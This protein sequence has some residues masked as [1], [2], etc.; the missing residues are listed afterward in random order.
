MV[1]TANHRTY[2]K[3]LLSLGRWTDSRGN[4]VDLREGDLAAIIQGSP[5]DIPLKLGHSSDAFNNLV[6]QEM[7]I[8]LTALSGDEFGNGQLRLGIAGNFRV[9]GDRLLADLT[10]PAELGRLIDLG[11]L[12]NV[13]A[14]MRPGHPFVL[15]ALALLGAEDPAVG[16]LRQFAGDRSDMIYLTSKQPNKQP[17]KQQEARHMVMTMEELVTA[18]RDLA[19]AAVAPEENPEEPPMEPEETPMAPPPPALTAARPA[20][21]DLTATRQLSDRVSRLEQENRSLRLTARQVHYSQIGAAYPHIEDSA[22]FGVDMAQ[23]ELT[24]PAAVSMMMTEH[25]R[26]ADAH[27]NSLL[28]T[29]MSVKPVVNP[30]ASTHPFT[31]KME[32][33][34]SREGLNLSNR[35][36]YAR[37]FTKASEEYRD[38][39]LSYSSTGN[40]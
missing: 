21:A 6:A 26:I 31:V 10:V 9:E 1:T 40:R 36:E 2:T 25:E 27:N 18:L 12:V 20:A 33:L 24:A 3:E 30:A 4:L 11:M 8:P 37:A 15:T 35:S 28:F 16:N 5:R 14:E 23:L 34:A 38:L 7:G 13:S 39:F 32:E 17:N 22:Q 29:K 19:E